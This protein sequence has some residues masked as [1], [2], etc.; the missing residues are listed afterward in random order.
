MI[1]LIVIVDYK[2][3]EFLQNMTKLAELRSNI[4]GLLIFMSANTH[5]HTYPEF[6]T[7]GQ[8]IN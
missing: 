2:F 5:V 8:L 7:S 6:Y 1:Y 3:K 4:D